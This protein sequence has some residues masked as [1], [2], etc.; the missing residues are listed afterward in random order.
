MSKR[1][2]MLHVRVKGANGSW[3]SRAT[4]CDRQRDE[5]IFY[6]VYP[7][8]VPGQY[9]GEVSLLLAGL[10]H[11]QSAVCFEMQPG[12]S[13]VRCRSSIPLKACGN[14]ASFEEFALTNILAT[15]IHLPI[16]KDAANGRITRRG[17]SELR[18]KR[19]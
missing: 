3:R 1:G 19:M 17:L 13:I 2:G 7:F 10:N 4:I 9:R 5:F 6:S 18:S 8:Q 16:I 12:T 14:S 11:G 15:D